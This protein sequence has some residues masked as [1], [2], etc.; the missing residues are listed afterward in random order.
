MDVPEDLIPG[1]LVKLDELKDVANVIEQSFEQ[2][3]R[4]IY[5]PMKDAWS[6]RTTS[7]KR[8]AGKR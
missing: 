2:A 3:I 6:I 8:L 4:D 5:I 7:R 1:A